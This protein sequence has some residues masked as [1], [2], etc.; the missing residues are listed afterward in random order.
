MPS[1]TDRASRACFGNDFAESATLPFLDPLASIGPFATKLKPA[2]A[3][4]Y[5]CSPEF[6]AGH[7][8]L[9]TVLGRRGVTL[10]N[11]LWTFF[12]EHQYC[13]DLDDGVEGDPLWMTSTCGAVIN[14]D[15]VTDQRGPRG[16]VLVRVVAFG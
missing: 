2:G 12:R 9:V 4:G 16:A 6:G 7:A 13:G 14:R 15:T 5:Q 3:P 10:F 1:T 8:L 11:A